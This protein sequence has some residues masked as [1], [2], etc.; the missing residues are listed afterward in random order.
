MNKLMD[1]LGER[2]VLVHPSPLIVVNVLLG[3]LGSIISIGQF[4]FVDGMESNFY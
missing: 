3:I 4:K 2:N 1:P